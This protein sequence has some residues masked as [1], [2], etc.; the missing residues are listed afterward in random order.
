MLPGERPQGPLGGRAARVSA[1]RAMV[2][3]AARV[4]AFGL[5]Y[6]L[7]AVLGAAI[8]G[9]ALPFVSFWPPSG[10][11]L[12]GLLLTPA[13]QWPG[14]MLGAALGNISFDVLHGIPFPVSLGFYAGN[15]LHAAAGSWAVHRLVTPR[16][17]LESVPE[18]FGVLLLG[19]VAGAGLGGLIG[20]G[21]LV[22]AERSHDF[23]E[24]WAQWTTGT[25]M[26]TLLVTPVVLSW[27]G[28]AS[29][30]RSA[31]SA[32]WWLEVAA[33]VAALV[34]I[35]M[36]GGTQRELLLLPPLLWSGVRFGTK[37]ASLSCLLVALCLGV[38]GAPLLFTWLPMEPSTGHELLTTK[39]FLG[40]SSIVALVP[41]I[42]LSQRARVTGALQASELRLE[43]ANR[44]KSEFLNMLSHELRNPLAPIRNGLYILSRAP[45]GSEPARRA[46]AIIGRQVSNLTHLVDDLL[47]MTRINRGKVQL[48]RERLELNELT[49]RMVEDYRSVFVESDVQLEVQTAPRDIWV[50]GDPT[51]LAQVIGNLLQ[52]AAKFTPPGGRTTVSVDTDPASDRAVVHVEDT[53]PG[54][55][56]ELLPRLFEPFTQADASLDRAKGGLGLGL[57]LVR[58]LVEMHGGSVGAASSGRGK[59]ACLTITLPLAAPAE[60]SPKRAA[61]TAAPRRVLVV[62]DNVDSAD[63]LREVLELD[64]HEVAVVYRGRE[65][66]EK[67]RV[68]RPDIVLC[69]I[70][71]PDIDGYAVARALRADEELRRFTLVALTGYA[72]P[73]D[74][75]RARAAG[76]DAHL[77]KP[78]SMEA[79]ERVLAGVPRDDRDE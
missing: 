76:F 10:I 20:A 31:R 3:P 23:V 70:G 69:D 78:V 9:A 77:A 36:F 15:T 37:G 16:P 59:G 11:Y 45:P 57:A 48:R 41:A 66:L 22:Q 54:I 13:R 35:T 71:L 19:G 75:T 44:R 34:V 14:I 42:V 6:Y 47:D 55:S 60:P 62:E 73:D 8:A 12:G 61:T 40:V 28:D 4:L 51:R 67:A 58:S 46:Q 2:L 63:S 50:N 5:S 65:A 38:S 52:N 74:A 7:C 24:T 1:S 26:A 17:K 72:Q 56:P 39:V 27:F 33:L 79:L 53:G 68:F 21:V 25:A 43:E 32:G 29:D 49:Q 18:L 30:E 64:G